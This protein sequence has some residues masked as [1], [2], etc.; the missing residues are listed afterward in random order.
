VSNTQKNAVSNFTTSLRSTSFFTP[1]F[2]TLERNIFRWTSLVQTVVESYNRSWHSTIRMSPHMAEFGDEDWKDEDPLRKRVREVNSTKSLTREEIREV[3]TR[4][5]Q[6]RAEKNCRYWTK[7]K[8]T[9]TYEVGQVVR[10]KKVVSKGS[11]S[12]LP[13]SK[14]S[15]RK[16]EDLLPYRGEEVK[17]NGQYRIRWLSKNAVWPLGFEVALST[18]AISS[19]ASSFKFQLCWIRDRL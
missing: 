19:Q 10:S 7:K 9:V 11:N 8:Q 5:L 12:L 14:K 3:V 13:L 16:E 1:Q 6:T 2:L 18:A 15:M 17:T 4:N